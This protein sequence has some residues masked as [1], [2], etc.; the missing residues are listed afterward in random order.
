MIPS[1]VSALGC[2]LAI[3]I[4][5]LSEVN[6]PK[7]AVGTHIAIRAPAKKDVRLSRSR[8]PPQIFDDEAQ[9]QGASYVTQRM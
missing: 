1:S 5:S 8:L 6:D 7:I 9:V 4:S 3:E 2:F